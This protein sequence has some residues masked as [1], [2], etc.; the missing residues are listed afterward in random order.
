[1]LPLDK[2]V[3]YEYFKEHPE[4][5]RQGCFVTGMPNDDYHAYEGVSS[6]GLKK[7]DVSPAHF[8]CDSFKRSRAMDIGSAIHCMTHE[9]DLFKTSYTLLPEVEDRRKPEYKSAKKALGEEFVFVGKEVV[10]LKGMYNSIHNNKTA[11]AI[12]NQDGYAELSAFVECP[13]TGVL[14]RVR[15][16]WITVH[17]EESLDLKSTTK[18]DSESFMYKIGELGYHISGAMYSDV[19]EM[20][21]GRKLKSFKLFPVEKEAPF[22]CKVY[23]LD[24][25][26]L[27]I[28]RDYYNRSIDTYVECEKTGEWPCYEDT[29]E[30]IGIAPKI[31]YK[32]EE[33]FSSSE[34]IV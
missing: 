4:L 6:T 5:A 16:D 30:E 32:W 33:E 12:Y 2:V 1:M 15:F 19:Y 28:G 7:I 10:S 24:E 11:M 26:S 27:T 20:I 31:F 14:L 13:R 29:E 23:P 3:T 18:A 9:P 21:T 17:T 22:G 8:K 25:G 34:E